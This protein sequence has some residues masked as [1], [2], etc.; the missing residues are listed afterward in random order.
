MFEGPLVNHLLLWGLV[1][2]SVAIVNHWVLHQ[3]QRKSWVREMSRFRV[4]LIAELRVLSDLYYL[5]LDLIDQGAGY[6]L[7]GR[8]PLIMCKG[9]INRF[10][11]LL[12]ESV[13]GQVVAILARNELIDSMLSARAQRHGNLTFRFPPRAA[14]LQDVKRYYLEGVDAIRATTA[15]LEAGVPETISS[16]RWLSN[17]AQTGQTPAPERA[18]A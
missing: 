1:V 13:I 10:S 5:N 9:N 4:G 17:L 16:S 2:I 14:N 15:A 8:P 11:T 3:R 12:D 18:P 6:L 7:S